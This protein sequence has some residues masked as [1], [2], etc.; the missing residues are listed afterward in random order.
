MENPQL[1]DRVFTSADDEEGHAT[2]PDGT[3]LSAAEAA[4]ARLEVGEMR[5]QV[6]RIRRDFADD[7]EAAVGQAKE[8]IE[9]V[10]KTIL[11]LTGDAAQGRKD[12]PKLV[13]R[14]LAHLD[15][16][17][18]SSPATRPSK[19]VRRSGCSAG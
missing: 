19:C 9:S 18:P 2:M 5:R 11:G 14:T 7:P 6:E 13:T 4:A 8:L 15:S 1:F 10:C 17:Q 3:V 12:L 16:T